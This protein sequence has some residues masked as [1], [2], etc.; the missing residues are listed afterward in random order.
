[1]EYKSLRSGNVLCNCLRN[2]VLV[3]NYRRNERKITTRHMKGMSILDFWA[4]QSTN[5]LW[6]CWWYLIKWGNTICEGQMVSIPP[7]E[8]RGEVKSVPGCIKAWLSIFWSQ[9][10]VTPHAQFDTLMD[11]GDQRSFTSME[12]EWRTVKDYWPPMANFLKLHHREPL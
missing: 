9:Q 6:T 5:Q 10:L 3:A 7:V 2:T 12:G 1:M 11:K 4:T 8:L